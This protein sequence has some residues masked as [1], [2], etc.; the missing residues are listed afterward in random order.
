MKVYQELERILKSKQCNLSVD[1]VL[2]IAKT[3]T[4]LNIKLPNSGK[5]ISKTMIIT[6]KQK[7]IADL[8]SDDFWGIQKR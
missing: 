7:E 1:K 3:V 4:T 8:F 5:T 2:E 6:E